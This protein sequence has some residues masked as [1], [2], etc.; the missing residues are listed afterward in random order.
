M[1]S[2]QLIYSLA[3]TAFLAGCGFRLV[4]ML[5]SPSNQDG[6]ALRQDPALTTRITGP[7]DARGCVDYAAALNQYFSEGVTRENNS[8]SLLVQ[9][10]GPTEDLPADTGQF[11][12]LL[13][14]NAPPASGKYF[15]DLDS[16]LGDVYV[17]E[18]NQAA[19][20]RAVAMQRPW[21][22]DEFPD[23]QRWL[24]QNRDPLQIATMAVK[25]EKYFVPLLVDYSADENLPEGLIYAQRYGLEVSREIGRALVCR[26]MLHLSEGHQESAWEDILSAHRLGRLVG[27]GP[28]I[29]DVLVGMAIEGM[30]RRAHVAFWQN[31]SLTT[32]EVQGYRRQYESL[33]ARR[34][35]EEAV[36]VGERMA[37]LDL[38]QECSRGNWVMARHSESN[39]PGKWTSPKAGGI[40]WTA[41][42]SDANRWFD[43]YVAILRSGDVQLRHQRSAALEDEMT[44]SVDRTMAAVFTDGPTPAM[45][46]ILFSLSMPSFHAVCAANDRAEQNARN[47]NAAIALVH[48][49]SEHQTFPDSLEQLIPEYLDR[50]PED[51]YVV[52]PLRY[53]RTESG[54]VL[55]S[56]GEDGIDHGGIDNDRLGK[57]DDLVI[58]FGE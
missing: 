53:R 28:T 23:I 32:E 9:A 6:P 56:V 21:R 11:F 42:T 36:H 44:E 43:R 40:D 3:V 52:E 15:V 14:V 20:D 31:A 25:R 47:L 45:A 22:A 7:L 37:I 19:D 55:Y 35:V 2:R 12:S 38:V 16:S 48:F 54:F 4:F 33:P 39:V 51:L 5:S 57:G 49:R 27:R 8:M 1:R 10:I 30:A 34:G 13:G 29:L 17:P 46:A 18:L 41:I 26:A 50:L 58:R 24:E